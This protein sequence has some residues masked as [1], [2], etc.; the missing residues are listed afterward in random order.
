MPIPTAAPRLLALAVGEAPE[1]H[2]TT[3]YEPLSPQGTASGQVWTGLPGRPQGELLG[4]ADRRVRLCLEGLE[5]KPGSVL[6]ADQ[7]L[8]VGRRW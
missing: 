7:G 8:W 1:S 5:R 2:Q 4:W 6:V 3:E